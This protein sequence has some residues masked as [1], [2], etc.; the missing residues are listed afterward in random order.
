VVAWL[1][2]T[3]L[4]LTARRSA[5]DDDADADIDPDG[6]AVPDGEE[7]REGLQQHDAHGEV[8]R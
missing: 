2:V 6:E 1:V 5:G 7:S 3:V 8:A 4:A